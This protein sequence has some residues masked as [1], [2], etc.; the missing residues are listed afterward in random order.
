M[1]TSRFLVVL[2]SAALIAVL[3]SLASAQS[4]DPGGSSGQSG[5]GTSAPQGGDTTGDSPEIGRPFRGLFGLGDSGRTG[6]SLSGSLFGAYDDNV[7]ATLPGRPLDA[8]YARSGWYTGANGQG[9]FNW[10]GENAAVNGYAT[11]GTSYYPDFD[12]PMVP[13]YSGGIGFNR[14]LGRRSSIHASQGILYSPYFL[15]GFFAGLPDL[16]ELPAPPV[17]SDPGVDV[18]SNRIVRTSTSVGFSRQLSRASTFTT[19]YSYGRSSY[20]GT[21]RLAHTQ[22][23]SATFRRRM[24]AH[25]GLHVGYAYRTMTSNAGVPGEPDFQRDI[26]DINVGVDY[27][28]SFAVSMSRR[29]RVSFASG[30]SYFAGSRISEQNITRTTRSR[31]HVTGSADLVHEMGRTWSASAAYRRSVSF[32]ELVFEPI[33]SDS[34]SGSLAGL[35]GRRNELRFM[36][37]TSRGNVGENRPGNGFQS[38]SATATL[39]R[40]LNRHMATY[41]TYGYYRHDFGN[42]VLLP[43]SFPHYLD[44]NGVR[45]GLSVF[46]PLH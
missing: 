9:M 40:A 45:F 17:A 13:S 26:Q 10:R 24:T 28:R 42:S 15:N 36:V 21:D 32:S 37:S 3:P 2:V 33:T 46:L 43:D 23:G 22:A 14:T 31:F 11:A 4:S 25:A 16:D 27:N 35:L 39:R 30:T 12:R 7:G 19:G 20:H 18:S 6:A 29:T 5:Q 44:R 8:R 1:T 34:V 38:S 41:V